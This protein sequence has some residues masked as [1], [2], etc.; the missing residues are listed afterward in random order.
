MS[1]NNWR[2]KLKLQDKTGKVLPSSG[3]GMGY[4]VV[5]SPRGKL[6]P[7]RFSPGES[8]RIIEN[9]GLP[10]KDNKELLE[11]LVYNESYPIYISAPSKNGRIGGVYLTKTGIKAFGNGSLSEE[12]GTKNAISQG[13]DVGIGDG[14]LQS[15]NVSLNLENAY[16]LGSLTISVD[17][18][19]VGELVFTSVGTGETFTVAGGDYDGL[20]GEINTTAN[21]LEV[22]FNSS[23]TAGKVV[24]ASWTADMSEA[25]MIISNASFQKDDLGVVWKYDDITKLHMVDILRKDKTGSQKSILGGGKTI[26]F[27]PDS[28]DGFG[29]SNYAPNVLIS[30]FFEIDMIDTIEDTDFSGF[31]DVET[32]IAMIGGSRGDKHLSG[33]D[34]ALGYSFAERKNKYVIDIFFD[35]TGDDS[36]PAVFDNLRKNYQQFSK[37]ILPL[38]PVDVDAAKVTM[39]ALGL[40]NRGLSV[41]WNWAIIKNLY[42]SSGNVVSPLT[43]EVAVKHADILKLGYGGMAP[44]WIDENGMGGQLSSG[45]VVEMLYDADENELKDLDNN[46][47]NPIVFDANYGILIKSRRTTQ[48]ALSDYSFI[49]YSGAA[50]YILRNVIEQVLPFQLIKFNDT[51]HRTL[52]A[53]K[54]KNIIKP[55]TIKPTNVVY[56]YAV[57]CDDEN[58]S[59]DVLDREEFVLSV[60]VQFTRKSRTIVFNFINSP[61]SVDI[62]EAFV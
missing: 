56:N 7:V 54:C 16:N 15:F 2:I 9:Y 34:L 21:T 50:D 10:N 55:M 4:T 52:V 26:S 61:V 59:G 13:I 14:T 47:I 17:D 23:L 6:T 28:V 5:D 45:R 18:E 46:R 22:T 51:A 11:A 62:E 25:V 31:V 40:D 30:D 58:N 8:Q 32:S 12:F 35:A 43:G 39:K 60:A 44:A 48:V 3:S 38:P 24:T 1:D 33:S 42:A 29:L 53:G 36:I 19:S 57:K 41:Y 20:S 49:G 27:D 37:F